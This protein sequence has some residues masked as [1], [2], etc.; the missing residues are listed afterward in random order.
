MSTQVDQSLRLGHVRVD[1]DLGSGI[2]KGKERYAPSIGMDR[3]RRS[4]TSTTRRTAR[5]IA[6]NTDRN[7]DSAPSGNASEQSV[8][9]NTVQPADAG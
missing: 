3:S 6:P 7:T 4:N 5:S 8:T 2:P 1:K 9:S